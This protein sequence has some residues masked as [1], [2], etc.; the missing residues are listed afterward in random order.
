M[1]TALIQVELYQQSTIVHFCIYKFATL[2]GAK[3]TPWLRKVSLEA[4]KWRRRL[5]RLQFSNHTLWLVK[6]NQLKQWGRWSGS[7]LSFFVFVMHNFDCLCTWIFIFCWKNVHIY[8]S[9]SL[10]RRYVV[11]Y[12]FSRYMIELWFEQGEYILCSVSNRTFTFQVY[13]NPTQIKNQH[14]YFVGLKATRD[15]PHT[16]NMPLNSE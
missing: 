3:D 10:K 4:S 5:V 2:K 9:V 16:I 1:N 15:D 11:V 7:C 13:V 6:T 12:L 14:I 8:I